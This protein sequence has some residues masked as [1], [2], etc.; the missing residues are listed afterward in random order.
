MS[1]LVKSAMDLTGVM[2]VITI[3]KVLQVSHGVQVTQTIVM[4]MKIVF[5]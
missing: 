2:T 4:G 3:S 1:G 5:I